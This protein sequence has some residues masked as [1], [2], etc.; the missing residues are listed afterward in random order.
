MV[1]PVP[2]VNSVPTNFRTDVDAAPFDAADTKLKLP[3]FVA[4]PVELI[5]QDDAAL[6]L[7]LKSTKLPPKPEL[8]L[9]PMYVPAVDHDVTAVAALV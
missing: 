6:P 4:I 9:I 1:V 5:V 8:V 3:K 2:P 7:I